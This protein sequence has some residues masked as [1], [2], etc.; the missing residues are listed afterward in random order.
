MEIKALHSL[1]LLLKRE[2]RICILPVASQV[3]L[4]NVFSRAIE[5]RGENFEIAQYLTFPRSS[6]FVSFIRPKTVFSKRTLLP[7]IM[8][9]ARLQHLISNQIAL[10]EDHQGMLI[11]RRKDVICAPIAST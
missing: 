2:E 7:N 4:P 3:L 8:E 1:C 11:D 6:I 10:L 9:F 5:N